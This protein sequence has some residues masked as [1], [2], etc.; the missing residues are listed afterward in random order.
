MSD[1]LDMEALEKMAKAAAEAIGETPWPQ[2]TGCGCCA[3]SG[4]S[5]LVEAA[6]PSTVLGLLAEVRRLRAD[7][8]KAREALPGLLDDLESA[9][10]ALAVYDACEA[11]LKR[12]L[13]NPCL[14]EA[15]AKARAAV[16]AAL[17]EPPAGGP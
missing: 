12:F 5:D 8:E 17:A 9:T 6:S 3:Y 10:A 15:V 11:E 13:T 7:R 16:L 2:A 1:P 14:E 4:T